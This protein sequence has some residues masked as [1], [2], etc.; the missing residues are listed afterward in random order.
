M[1]SGRS[2]SDLNKRKLPH[3]NDRVNKRQLTLH[4]VVRPTSKTGGWP[5]LINNKFN[6]IRENIDKMRFSIW[7]QPPYKPCQPRTCSNPNSAADIAVT[8]DAQ[9]KPIS[10][11][12][13]VIDDQPRIIADNSSE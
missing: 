7:W 10:M 4:R 3:G 2:R 12:G 13:A 9:K 11:H 6:M 5:D 1:R 8:T